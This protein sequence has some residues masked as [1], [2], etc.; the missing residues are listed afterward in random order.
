MIPLVLGGIALTAVGYGL[1]KYCEEDMSRCDGFNDKLLDFSDYMENLEQK[2]MGNDNFEVTMPADEFFKFTPL[3]V[4]SEFK[5]LVYEA[6][7]KPF[8]ALQTQL[9]GSD[10]TPIV[11]KQVTPIKSGS[12]I[13]SKEEETSITHYRYALNYAHTQLSELLPKLEEMLAS[14]SD[15]TA[16][17]TAQR[18]TLEKAYVY[19]SV[20]ATLL[21]AKVVKKGGEFSKKLDGKVLEAMREMQEVRGQ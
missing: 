8:L 3:G 7:M 13:L 16:F 1:K 9:Q 17:D 20:L 2:L 21:T 14:Q 15:L 4:L 5:E 10:A 12:I 11:C 6:S 18:K 19:A